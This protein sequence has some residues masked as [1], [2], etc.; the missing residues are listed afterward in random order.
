M[1]YTIPTLRRIAALS[2]GELVWAGG[3]RDFRQIGLCECE[4]MEAG[5]IHWQIAC[6]FAKCLVIILVLTLFENVHA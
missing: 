1:C 4:G 2:R 5:S 3:E 6:M